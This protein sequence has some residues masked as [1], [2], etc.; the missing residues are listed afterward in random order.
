MIYSDPQGW[1]MGGCHD[2]SLLSRSFFLPSLVKF[3]L[4]K[5]E[6]MERGEGTWWI[7]FL[8]SFLFVRCPHDLSVL[9]NM[10]RTLLTWHKNPSPSFF[11]GVTSIMLPPFSLCHLYFSLFRMMS[12]LLMWFMQFTSLGHKYSSSHA[13]VY[14][15]IHSLTHKHTHAYTLSRQISALKSLWHVH[16]V[17]FYCCH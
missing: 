14:V 3:K 8:F 6:S 13:Q 17:W 2:V 15:L 11:L 9:H 4:Y 1:G 12:V 16:V 10:Y 7:F 5:S